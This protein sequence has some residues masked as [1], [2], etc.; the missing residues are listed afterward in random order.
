MGRKSHTSP[1]ST[2][3][4]G[5]TPRLG[6]YIPLGLV[7]YGQSIGILSRQDNR[8]SSEQKMILHTNV[9]PSPQSWGRDE[10]NVVH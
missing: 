7:G 9:V 6:R 4:G 1:K 5:S 2:A 3:G 8:S 10:K